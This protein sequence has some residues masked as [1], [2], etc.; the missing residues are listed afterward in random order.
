MESRAPSQLTG[1]EIGIAEIDA[2]HR[3]LFDLL[4]QLKSWS[5]KGYEYSATI[6]TL[7]KLADYTHTH[8]S[9]EES[10]MRMLRY[11]DISAH[12]A[13]HQRLKDSLEEFRHS[14]LKEGSRIDLS[15][16]I[17]SWLVDH[18]SNVD[19][20]YVEHF[21]AARIDPTAAPSRFP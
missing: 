5:G 2:Q 8:F 3:V 13:E 1:F 4:R 12:I 18:I 15:D 11:P 9:V 6:D 7:N 10:L 17:Q 14:V 20:K 21:L 16:F 19:R